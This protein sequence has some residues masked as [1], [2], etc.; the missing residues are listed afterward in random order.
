MRFSAI[1]YALFLFSVAPVAAQGRHRQVQPR[2][3]LE[4]RFRQHGEEKIRHELNLNNMQMQKLH[5]MSEH[6]APRSRVLAKQAR[7]VNLALRAELARGPQADQRHIAQLNSQR[8]GL[9]RQRF[10]L[11][12]EEQRQLSTFMTPLQ[13]AQY[14]GLQAQLRQRVQE[15]RKQQGDGGATPITP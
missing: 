9:Q 4:R 6:L 5:D 14:L 10:E 13:Q 15:F 2:S 3:E 11:Q 1:G 12:Q 8:S 7:D